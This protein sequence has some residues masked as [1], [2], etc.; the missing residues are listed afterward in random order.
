MENKIKLARRIVELQL[1]NPE[2][3]LKEFDTHDCKF[4]CEQPT[5]K[6]FTTFYE[7]VEFLLKTKE[8]FTDHK[9][10]ILD[11]FTNNTDK[12]CLEYRFNFTFT[13]EWNG[14]KPT[15]KSF[16][17]TGVQ[18]FWF[19]GDKLTSIEFISDEAHRWIEIG[20]PFVDQTSVIPNL[21]TLRKLFST[22]TKDWETLYNPHVDSLI[23]GRGAK[24]EGAIHG[25][26]GV[27]DF[28][29]TNKDILTGIKYDNIKHVIS[30]DGRQIVS[31]C[32]ERAGDLLYE[33][34]TVWEF[35]D[36]HRILKER[37][38]AERSVARGTA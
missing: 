18:I 29:R 23:L 5:F 37:R 13:G 35:D 38:F 12:V 7:F 28:V 31:T 36:Q 22:E 11:V 2:Q 1:N 8:V 19:R 15:G 34:N 30:S 14:I 6:R 25:S 26:K 3:L 9:W 20:V 27:I 24:G 10:E 17:N 16:T 33:W 32:T 4:I 21:E